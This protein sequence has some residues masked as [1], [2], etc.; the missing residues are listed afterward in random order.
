MIFRLRK[1]LNPNLS[2]QAVRWDVHTHLLPG[3]DDGARD[4]DEAFLGIEVLRGLGYHGTV[5]T[6]H[7]YPEVFDNNERDLTHCF[8][9]FQAKVA[10]VFPGFLLQLG[11]EYMADESF[12]RRVYDD[13]KRLLRF[14]P[15]RTRVLVEFSAV[16]EPVYADELFDECRRQ[17]LQPVVAHLERYPVVAGVGG[18]DRVRLWRNRGALLQMNLESLSGVNG[19]MIKRTAEHLLKE[20]LVDLVGSDMHR[21]EAAEKN[22]ARGWASFSRAAKTFDVRHQRKLFAPELDEALSANTPA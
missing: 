20:S 10:A 22:L 13:P 12:V 7:I 11:A 2:P 14:G 5:I 9:E 18:G 4:L 6:P 1:R 8:E 16:L 17:G 21:P 19:R 3:V 15:H